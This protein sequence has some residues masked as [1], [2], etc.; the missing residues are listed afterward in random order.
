MIEDLKSIFTKCV[1]GCWLGILFA[2]KKKI[3]IW[4]HKAMDEGYQF[5]VSLVWMLVMDVP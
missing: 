2:E 5:C 1:H 3:D 4:K